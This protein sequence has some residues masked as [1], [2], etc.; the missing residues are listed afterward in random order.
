M[1]SLN[2]FNDRLKLTLLNYLKESEG[3]ILFQRYERTRLNRQHPH[4]HEHRKKP[5]E[6]LKKRSYIVEDTNEKPWIQ[7]DDGNIIPGKSA[8]SPWVI[9]NHGVN[10][11]KR[12]V[13]V[14]ETL[15]RRKQWWVTWPSIFIS[16]L[17]LIISV[18]A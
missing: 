13:I 14:S 1:D 9:S 15:N 8:Y 7:D 18:I 17:A 6:E 2:N 12:K 10:A 11:I 5:D 3:L 16:A 4:I